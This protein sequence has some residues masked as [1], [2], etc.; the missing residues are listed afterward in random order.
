M[1]RI[2]SHGA[3]KNLIINRFTTEELVAALKDLVQE[4]RLKKNQAFVQYSEEI[5]IN[6]NQKYYYFILLLV[7]PIRY[8]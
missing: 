8:K 2:V 7:F 3:A 5:F 4:K 6:L 1:K